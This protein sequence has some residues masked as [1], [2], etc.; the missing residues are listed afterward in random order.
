[1]MPILSDPTVYFRS[2]KKGGTFIVTIM[3]AKWTILKILSLLRSRINC[4]KSWNK[5][6][7]LALNLLLHLPGEISVFNCTSVIQF[8]CGADSFIYSTLTIFKRYYFL[9]HTS[10]Q[11]NFLQCMFKIS[12]HTCFE[13]C[14]PLFNAVLSIQ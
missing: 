14:T 5:N 4:G 8:E 2:A 9:I 6:N 7:H 13:S 12:G 1:M 10:M 3:L 11:V